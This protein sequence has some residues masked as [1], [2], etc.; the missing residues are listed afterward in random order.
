MNMRAKNFVRLA[1]LTWAVVLIL[2]G[3]GTGYWVRHARTGQDLI[4]A[5]DA[6]PRLEYF[7]PPDSFSRIENTKGLLAGL[8]ARLRLA[9][10]Q[11]AV[12]A[13]RA[14]APGQAA[15]GRESDPHLAVAIRDL[16][17][18]MQELEGTEQALDCAEDLFRYLNM[19]GHFDRCVEMY[20]RA[21]YEHPTHPFV[22]KFAEDAI[23]VGRSA[24]REGEVLAGLN[25]LSAIPLEFQ[26]KD[27]VIAVLSEAKAVQG[28][29]QVCVAHSAAIHAGGEGL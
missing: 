15:S 8:C 5:A 9:A 21:L 20:V 6:I 1:P 24:G 14:S 26:G 22:A 13:W 4:L 12:V 25:H 10:A 11:N 27:R 2:A 29:T 23:R 17:Q 18:A 3:C 7:I 19:A 28:A 16:E